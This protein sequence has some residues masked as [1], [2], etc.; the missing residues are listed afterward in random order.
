MNTNCN[1]FVILQSFAMTDNYYVFVEMPYYINA[2]K[3]LWKA[4]T[5]KPTLEA[6]KFHPNEKVC[7]NIQITITC[8]LNFVDLVLHCST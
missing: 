6:M 4:I 1:T 5:G 3:M 7:L 2:V 8:L